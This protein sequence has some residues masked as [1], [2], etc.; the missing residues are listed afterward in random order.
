MVACLATTLFFGGWQVPWLKMDA[1]ANHWVYVLLGVM[2]FSIKVLVFCFV[3][4][5]IRWTL[6]RFRY[7]QLMTLGW[8]GLFPIAVVNVVVTA[9]VLVIF[10]AASQAMIT[11]TGSDF[12]VGGSTTV[13]VQVQDT[14]G[15]L[16]NTDNTTQIT[17]R[18]TLYGT[19]SGVVAG[20]GDGSYGIVGR[21]ET[22]TV[23]GGVATVTLTDLVA[24][25]FE[26]V[27]TNDGNLADPA[28]DSIT[29]TTGEAR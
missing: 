13:T 17:F 10:A 6:P 9:V 4:M 1:D 8:K 15:N 25:T 27:V 7:D 18:P 24:E 20:T 16:V 23:T 26:V 12:P 2:S 21:A 14:N 28:N 3:F 22:V 11:A 19:I 5:Q 29:V